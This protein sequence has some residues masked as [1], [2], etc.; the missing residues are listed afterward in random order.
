VAR[1]P[2]DV[3]GAP[4]DVRL[5]LQVEDVVVRRRHA[6]EVAARRV[7]DALRL[8]GR[9][10]RVHEEEEV[11]RVHWLGR[12]GLRVVGDVEVVQPHVAA[13]GH[14]HLVARAP[15]DEAAPD[16]RRGGHGLVGG[17]LERH[18]RA[19][20]PGLVLRD[21]HLAA[22]VV[23]PIGQ[24]VRREAAEHDGVRRAE[25]GAGE[26]R[27]RQLG[28]HPEVDR[29]RRP[30]GDPQLLEGVG[31]ANGVALQLRVGDR[32]RVA[33]LALPVV[34][35][36]VAESRLDVPVD[37]V[38]RDVEPPAQVPLGIGRLPLEN[39]CEG[40]VPRDPL[41]PFAF[42]ERLEVLLV[43]VRLRVRPRGEVRRRRVAALLEEQGVDRLAHATSRS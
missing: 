33:R 2:A 24:R 36:A 6:D 14:R 34:G 17:A 27:R 19:A 42:P 22:H 5:G 25:A 26:H 8:R 3:G 41:P 23:H 10:G 18:R 31:E 40:L 12:T 29:H 28:D 16:A 43:D 1:D 13:V 37:A 9:P 32:A 7:D 38:V 30:L 35:D 11:L 21:E 4:V 15:H 39:F 20:P